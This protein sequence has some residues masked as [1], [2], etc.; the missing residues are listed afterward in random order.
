MSTDIPARTIKFLGEA[1]CLGTSLDISWHA[2][3]PLILP[4]AQY[5]EMFDK[6]ESVRPP[7]LNI[8]YHFQTNGTL[9]TDDFC[10]FAKSTKTTIGISLDGPQDIHD[11]HR[12]NRIGHG[13]HRA[14][15]R[16]LSKLQD[17]GIPFSVIAVLT[18]YSL[19]RVDQLF[20]FFSTH[21][22][23]T[24]C[25]NLEE[26]VGDNKHT[27]LHP[28]ESIEAIKLFFGRYLE[29]L[30]RSRHRLWV[31]EIDGR[32][33]MLFNGT[34]LSDDQNKP[35]AVVSVNWKGDISTFSPELLDTKDPRFGN[36]V[37]GNVTTD[38][39][40]DLL[41]SEK[42]RS[43]AT[44]IATGVEACRKGCSYF[45]VCGG[46]SPA[47]KLAENKS[48]ASTE[49]ISCRLAIMAIT[50]VLLQ[51]IESRCKTAVHE[52]NLARPVGG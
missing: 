31:R 4:V 13:S 45:A 29:L 50:D 43:V 26:I 42:L 15:M 25:F 33:G 39:V 5:I 22:I 52:S 10:R 8:A 18:K 51:Y 11:K 47:A 40:E 30:S 28:Q 49:T 20:E 12:P 34:T 35:L 36:F 1:S 19:A 7:Y 27:S 3:E 37:F 32:L 38:K 23:R 16:G 41:T 46:G 6:I 44:E 21:D 14:V 48:F 24:I 9:I 2:G 17:H